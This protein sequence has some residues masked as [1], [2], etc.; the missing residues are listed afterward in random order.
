MSCIGL[1]SIILNILDKGDSDEKTMTPPQDTTCK[2][3]YLSPF[4]SVSRGKVN[5]QTER[6]KRNSMYLLDDEK[7]KPETPI[8]VR[9]TME[10][11]QYFRLQLE[12]EIGRLNSLCD[13]WLQYSSGENEARLAET[14]GKDMIDAAIGQTK[15]LTSKKMMQFSSLIDRCEAG[16]TGIGLRANDGSEDTKPVLAEDLEG[17]WD[18]MRLQSDNVDKRFDNLKR[19]KANDWVDPDEVVPKPKPKTKRKVVPK[20]AAAKP[21]SKASRDLKSF[22]LKANAEARK[23]RKQKENEES[24]LNITPK[25]HLIVVRDRKSFSPAR[26]VLRVSTGSGGRPSIAGSSRKSISGSARKS[27][28]GSARMS[29]GPNTLLRSAIMGAVAVQEARQ[30]TPPPIE[31]PRRMSILKT[32]G[33][34]KQD[35]IARRVI[36]SAKKKVRHFQFAVEEGVING[37]EEAQLGVEKLEDCEEDMSMEKNT[38]AKSSQAQTEDNTPPTPQSAL[39]TCTLRNRKVKMRYSSDLKYD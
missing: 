17:W 3:N 13:E 32:P 25:H 38:S 2:P 20:D 16:A 22:L 7:M 27:I 11:V 21:T 29:I 15:L 33:T 18:M 36:F 35:S 34:K 14:G 1:I 4:V 37:D 8:A 26:T 5:S 10:S 24:I 39:R 19:W 12:N 28:S 6:S 23:K 31:T 9:R 30:Q